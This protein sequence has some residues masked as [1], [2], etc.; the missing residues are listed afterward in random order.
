[1]IEAAWSALD[2][3]SKCQDKNRS[4][5]KIEVEDFC[6][7]NSSES[8]PTEP[9]LDEMRLTKAFL[10]SVRMNLSIRQVL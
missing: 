10:S 9:S 1:M 3:A 6:V 5:M 2:Q 7:I 4:A 8:Q